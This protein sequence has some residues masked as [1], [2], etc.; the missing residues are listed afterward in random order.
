VAV[1]S[2]TTMAGHPFQGQAGDHLGRTLPY[3]G[4]GKEPGKKGILSTGLALGRVAVGLSP[5]AS[6]ARGLGGEDHL[7]FPTENRL[8][9]PAA[10]AD[11]IWEGS[12]DHPRHPA[13]DR[14]AVPESVKRAA[15][16]PGQGVQEAFHRVGDSW[17][18]IAQLPVRLGGTCNNRRLPGTVRA[19]GPGSQQQGCPPGLC[20]TGS[21]HAATVGGLRKE[22]GDGDCHSAA[23]CR[24]RLIKMLRQ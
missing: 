3:R 15:W 10:S 14:P 7:L 2:Q 21:G 1:D 12:G 24:A 19:A 20:E 17:G 22:H 8:A 23:T 18:N 5:L 13:Q 16:A 11:S 6:R 9:E 4:E